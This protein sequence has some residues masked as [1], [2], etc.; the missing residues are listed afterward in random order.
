MLPRVVD[1]ESQLSDFKYQLQ[2]AASKILD[3]DDEAISLKHKI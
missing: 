2:D 3:M 1:L